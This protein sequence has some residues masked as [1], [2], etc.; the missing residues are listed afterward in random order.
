MLLFRDEEHVDRWCAQWRLPRGATLS[1]STAWRLADAWFRDDRGAP[2]WKR[3]AVDEVEAL[4]TS[5][6]LTTTFWRLR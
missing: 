1:L 3:P 5:L 6:K 4:F 2:Q